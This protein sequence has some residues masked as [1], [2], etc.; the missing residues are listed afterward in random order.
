MKCGQHPER[1]P[2][3]GIDNNKIGMISKCPECLR[4]LEY[5]LSQKI[6]SGKIPLVSDEFAD[7]IMKKIGAGVQPGQPHLETRNKRLVFAHYLM[8][9]AA[10]IIMVMTGCFNSVLSSSQL[11]GDFIDGF[12]NEVKNETATKIQAGDDLSKS[13]RAGL[14]HF[15]TLGED[16]RKKLDK[17]DKR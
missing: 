17:Q 15:Y 14:K 1:W 2:E 9:S 7:R 12:F 4:V 16:Y 6:E 5:R 3:N 11:Y 10:T 8:A 13:I